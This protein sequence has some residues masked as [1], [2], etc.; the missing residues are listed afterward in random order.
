M[1]TLTCSHCEKPCGARV[2]SS[3]DVAS[4]NGVITNAAGKLSCKASNSVDVPAGSYLGSCFSC[5]VDGT[6]LACVCLDATGLAKESQLNLADC[7][8]GSISNE[9]GGLHC[10]SE[11]DAQ[12]VSQAEQNTAGGGGGDKTNEAQKDEV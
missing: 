3:I 2:A 8:E 6:L 10:T 5:T 1:T 12:S 4:C 7:H 11:P 9:Q